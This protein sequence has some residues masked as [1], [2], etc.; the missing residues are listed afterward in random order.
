MPCPCHA[1]SLR[2]WTAS[3]PFDLRS[4]TVF[5]S[6]ISCSAPAVL[7]K[8]GLQN[9][10]NQ[11]GGG[12]QGW[13]RGG[14]GVRT[15]RK[16]EIENPFNPLNAELNPTCHLLALLE[17]HHILHVSRIRVN[18]CHREK[19]SFKDKME[20]SVLYP[21]YIFIKSYECQDEQNWRSCHDSCAMAQCLLCAVFPI[22]K[23]LESRRRRGQR[24]EQKLRIQTRPFFVFS[25]VLFK[26]NNIKRS[27]CYVQKH[28]H[29][30]YCFV[31]R[32]FMNW[33]AVCIHDSNVDSIETQ[34]SSISITGL[35]A[36]CHRKKVLAL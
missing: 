9:S 13:G 28:T 12:W 36:L 5:D 10:L 23:Q 34:P 20:T 6:H 29:T 31:I 18:V 30:S 27:K 24:Y 32:H 3:F 33:P 2:V 15:W 4:A 21:A 19:N 8:F 22:I 14:G 7:R 25:S 1:V 26:H 16:F 11:Y 17:T 35:F